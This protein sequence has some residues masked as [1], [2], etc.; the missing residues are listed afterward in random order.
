MAGQGAAAMRVGG[1]LA[2]AAL[3]LLLT[4]CG[5]GSA[6]PPDSF[7][8]LS[9]DDPG[10]RYG[11]PLLPGTVEVGRFSA[12]GVTGERALVYSNGGQRVRR[13]SYHHWIDSPP[14]LIQESLVEALRRVEAAEAVV[15]PELRLRSDWRVEGQLK[16]LEH[17]LTG[18]GGAEV[19]L[20]I[21]V[22][23][24]DARDGGLVM[25]DGFRSRRQVASTEVEPAVEAFNVALTDVVAEFLDRLAEATA[26]RARD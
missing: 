1:A 17:R 25:I 23:V 16:R 9:A 6:P 19:V 18:D 14:R 11:R 4:A 26:E 7:Y 8:R 20:A 12:D 3:V 2:A 15:T 5:G 24:V 13:Y 22:S 10:R 21:E